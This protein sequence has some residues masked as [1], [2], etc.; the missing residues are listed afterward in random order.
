[1]HSVPSKSVVNPADA[2]V[3]ACCRNHTYFESYGESD[4]AQS[5]CLLSTKHVEPIKS[6]DSSNKLLLDRKT[7]LKSAIGFKISISSH[8]FH[9][10]KSH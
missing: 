9:E 7:A 5:N 2:A 3:E 1:M 6:P 8:I 4:V 10:G